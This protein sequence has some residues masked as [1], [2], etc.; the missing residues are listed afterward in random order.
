MALSSNHKSYRLAPI[1]LRLVPRTYSWAESALPTE[2]T[3]HIQLKSFLMDS[4]MTKYDFGFMEIFINY[5]AI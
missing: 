4:N 3:S 2:Q 5:Y 1:Y